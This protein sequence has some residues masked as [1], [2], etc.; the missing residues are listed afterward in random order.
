M[1]Y[2]YILLKISLFIFM[3]DI[4]H[5]SKIFVRAIHIKYSNWTENKAISLQLNDNF[6]QSI[7]FLMH[8]NSQ[9]N[10]DKC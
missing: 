1:V 6:E 5:D 3:Y 8:L 7:I 10:K 2:F 9:R 4:A